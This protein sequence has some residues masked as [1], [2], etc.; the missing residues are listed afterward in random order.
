MPFLRGFSIESNPPKNDLKS[1]LREDFQ[2]VESHD[3][4]FA[5][6]P[7]FTNTI[8]ETTSLSRICFRTFILRDTQLS[9]FDLSFLRQCRQRANDRLEEGARCDDVLDIFRRHPI[10]AEEPAGLR[11]HTGMAREV[12]GRPERPGG[13][14]THFQGSS[15]GS[16]LT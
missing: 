9:S 5:I 10:E 12:S 13:A 4:N 1:V 8:D 15:T 14:V 2:L 16:P 7:I 11:G 3:R 6:R